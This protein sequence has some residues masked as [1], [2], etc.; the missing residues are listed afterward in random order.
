[1]TVPWLSIESVTFQPLVKLNH[2][3]S[4][5]PIVK[6]NMRKQC[7]INCIKSSKQFHIMKQQPQ[8]RLANGTMTFSKKA[9]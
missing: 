4:M 6:Y 3:A 8:S 2:S 1:M 7:L 5:L 9:I